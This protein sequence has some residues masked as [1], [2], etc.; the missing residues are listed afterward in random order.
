MFEFLKQYWSSTGRNRN[1]API[2]IFEDD[3]KRFES[4]R[5]LQDAERLLKGAV[6]RIPLPKSSL[7]LVIRWDSDD[8]DADIIWTPPILEDL[9]SLVD[10]DK[11]GAQILFEIN[12]ISDTSEKLERLKDE[13]KKY[14]VKKE[15]LNILKEFSAWHTVSMTSESQADKL[16]VAIGDLHEHINDAISINDVKEE[17]I[18]TIKIGAAKQEFKTNL[19]MLSFRISAR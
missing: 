14:H 7:S 19:A 4:L 11:T 6:K 13:Y 1:Y 10:D 3:L 15:L 9:V 17:I 18:D 12:K 5:N 8:L 2:D 16:G